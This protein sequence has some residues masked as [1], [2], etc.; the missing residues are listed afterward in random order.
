MNDMELFHSFGRD[1][2]DAVVK[3]TFDGVEEGGGKI[4]DDISIPRI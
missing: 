2:M 4:R 1:V 3:V